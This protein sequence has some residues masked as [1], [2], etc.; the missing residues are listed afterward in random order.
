MIL[1]A[2]V[3]LSAY[4]FWLPNDP[5]GSWSDFVRVWDLLRFGGAT[6]VTDRHSLARRPHDSALRAAAKRALMYPPVIFDGLQARAIARGFAHV[7]QRTNCVI[8]ACAIMPDHVHLVIGRHRYPIQ[9]VTNLLNGGA[10]RRLRFEGLDPFLPFLAA[11]PKGR[12][13]PS[14]WARK[15]WKVW[16]DSPEDVFRSIEYANDNPDKAGL[17]RQHW[18]FI[19]PYVPA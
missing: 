18:S 3:I 17:Q 2:H 4:G 11:G 7:V 15:Y 12:A 13:H 9:Q 5:R 8:H 6:K 14:P 16:L 19:T 10:T 1:A